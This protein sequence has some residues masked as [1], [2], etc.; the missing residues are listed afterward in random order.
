MNLIPADEKLCLQILEREELE[1]FV[2]ALIRCDNAGHGR[3]KAQQ[4]QVIFQLMLISR[5]H[6]CQ[7]AGLN[8]YEVEK[9]AQASVKRLKATLSPELTDLLVYLCTRKICIPQ[10]STY[11]WDYARGIIRSW[12]T[13]S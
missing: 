7:N 13:S 9:K 1:A 6:F 11:T 8:F 10:S 4:W 2:D 5:R 12:S 3:I